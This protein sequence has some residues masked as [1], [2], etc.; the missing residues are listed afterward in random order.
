MLKTT[1]MIAAALALLAT[2]AFGF[3]ASLV[4]GR[5]R[6]LRDAAAPTAL[7]AQEEHKQAPLLGGL[8]LWLGIGFAFVTAFLL[9]NDQLSS[10]GY[11]GGWRALST[12]LGSA[13][14]FGLVGLTVDCVRISRAELKIKTN[15]KDNLLFILAQLC[16]A[17][18]FLVQQ[19]MNGSL[20][21]MF[22]LPGIGWVD[23]G[24]WSWPVSMLLIIM[25]VNAVR[26]TEEPDGLCVGSGFVA[27]LV[28]LILAMLMLELEVPGDR[29][30]TALF[31]ASVAGGCIG[32]LFWNFWP[33]RL[34]PGSAGSMFLGGALVSIAWGLGRPELLI[35]ICAAYLLDGIGCLLK[36]LT[37]GRVCGFGAMH[38]GLVQLSW[39]RPALI[40]LGCGISLFGGMMAI[41]SVF[42]YG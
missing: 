34:R 6:R 33:A 42:L 7:P 26:I 36:T 31:A 40:W 14:A 3:P 18:L 20:G 12:M 5:V 16:V 24:G 23:L 10:N 4:F 15:W 35:F 1:A 13:M 27:A 39:K 11:I 28:F 21:T 17:G 41:L 22:C 38:C 8:V 2:C 37:R 9:T 30:V 19:A 32:F 25:T 29:Y